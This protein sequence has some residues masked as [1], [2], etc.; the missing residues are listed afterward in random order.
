[1]SIEWLH[2]PFGHARYTLF[3]SKK[4]MKKAGYEPSISD[5]PAS[6]L[7]YDDEIIVFFNK[8]AE[9]SPS[10]K[11]ALLVHECV[12]VWQEIKERMGEKEPS[13]EFEA[14]SI[15]LIFLGLLA[16]YDEGKQ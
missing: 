4:K 9:A 14:Y 10:E 7:V 1:M 3:T 5:A 2:S 13:S 6:T 15:Q 8:K 11:M 16:I 12:H